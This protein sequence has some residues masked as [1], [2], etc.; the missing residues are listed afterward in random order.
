MAF[1]FLVT[2]AWA[3]GSLYRRYC[4]R[5][6]A[7]YQFSVVQEPSA[8]SSRPL[9]SR[10]LHNLFHYFSLSISHYLF[11][12]ISTFFL[13]FEMFT[14]VNNCI[15]SCNRSYWCKH[16]VKT[17]RTMVGHVVISAE[18]TL[19]VSVAIFMREVNRNPG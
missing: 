14:N 7:Y 10:H 19:K 9:L 1:I 16:N 18:T 2:C 17:G 15:T 12:T 5:Q 6:C 11:L 13:L 8:S 4:L 3:Q